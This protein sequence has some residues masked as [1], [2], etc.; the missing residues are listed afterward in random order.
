MDRRR[1]QT[2]VFSRYW[3][4]GRRKNG[5]RFGE[6]ERIYVD[7]YHSLEIGLVLTLVFFCGSDLVLSLV[8]FNAG[9]EE[10]SPI[11]NWVLQS[12][13]QLG[14]SLVK[15]ATTVVGALILLVHIRFPKVRS[16]IVFLVVVYIGVF[17]Y[18]LLVAHARMAA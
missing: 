12:G 10:G 11:M 4:R 6:K 9:G 17:G 8:H 7:K 15:S 14:F 5:R 2:P 1:Y 18:H 16:S 3:L 13:G